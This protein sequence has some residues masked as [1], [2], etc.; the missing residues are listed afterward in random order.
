MSSLSEN[1]RVK[2][3]YGDNRR[4][5]SY[6][7]SLGLAFRWVAGS[8]IRLGSA[9]PIIERPVISGEYILHD[10]STDRS[11]AST[12]LPELPWSYQEAT[13]NDHDDESILGRYQQKACK[14][15]QKRTIARQERH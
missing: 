2:P 13:Y 1:K 11:E 15:E 4:G 8:S 9:R 6:N 14:I 3:R 5:S 10:E 7:Q 12:C